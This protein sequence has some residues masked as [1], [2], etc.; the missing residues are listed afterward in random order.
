MNKG[1]GVR[2]MGFPHLIPAVLIR[3]REISRKGLLAT[4]SGA[5]ARH[6]EL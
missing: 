5:L 2:Q 3:A 1:G 6:E 4:L